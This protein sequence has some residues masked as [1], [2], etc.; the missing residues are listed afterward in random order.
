MARDEFFFNAKMFILRLQANFS[1]FQGSGFLSNHCAT[2]WPLVLL[3]GITAFD[4]L[5]CESVYEVMRS[6][7]FNFEEGKRRIRWLVS[8]EGSS[9]TKG[10]IKL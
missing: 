6:R 9:N 3:R 2:A 1:T 8:F 10:I 7:H 4:I 5:Q